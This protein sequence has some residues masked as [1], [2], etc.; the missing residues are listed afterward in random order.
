MPEGKFQTDRAIFENEIWKH[1]LKFRLFFYIYGNA[2]FSEAG[3]D[4]GGIHISRGQF[5]RSFRGLQDDLEYIE[6]HAVK[7]YS[8]SQIK[9]AVDE[10][11]TEKRINFT[12]VS[13]GTL[14]T[15]LNYEQYQGFEQ[16]NNRSIE[17]RK[18][19]VG[20]EKEHCWN[21][22]KNVKNDKKLNTIVFNKDSW[23]YKFAT[24]L[25]GY[26]LE[27]NPT[28]KIPDNLQGWAKGF[29]EIF[30]IDKRS[31][32]EASEI[33]QFSQRDSFW[34]SNILS[35]KSF[36]KHYDTLKL[37]RQELIEKKMKE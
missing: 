25:K 6:N 1:T 9:R 31:T 16:F 28:A 36:R 27:N 14:F 37:K 2:V 15:V 30:R 35:P 24:A 18:N 4:K 21:N 22:N 7:R 3:V 12:V 17:Q 23:E 29:D 33:L 32:G 13:L 34:K 10:L 20:T 8:L 19:T 5:L 26:M 11:A